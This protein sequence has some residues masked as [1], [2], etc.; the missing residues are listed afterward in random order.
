MN[1]SAVD[2]KISRG[3]GRK[4][5]WQ[6][7]TPN[8]LISPQEVRTTI[9]A[10]RRVFQT[11]VAS[12]MTRLR[13]NDEVA[14]AAIQSGRELEEEVRSRMPTNEKLRDA[15][16]RQS[17]VF[18]EFALNNQ[19]KKTFEAVCSYELTPRKFQ[20][21]LDLCRLREIVEE[22]HLTAENGRAIVEQSIKRKAIIAGMKSKIDTED[23]D[24]EDMDKAIKDL[25]SAVATPD[26]IQFA[27]AKFSGG[28]GGGHK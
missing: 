27:L 21:M 20:D 13:A 24:E 7:E 19:N 4:C 3:E 25:K 5:E 6:Y 10:L 8:R 28:G 12:H 11:L 9:T 15:I 26:P 18:A 22:G 2:K 1:E 23:L 16:K 14:L 17:A